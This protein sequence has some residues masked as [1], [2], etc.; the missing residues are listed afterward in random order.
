M[1]EW[2]LRMPWP[3]DKAT[4]AEA[5]LSH[6]WLVTNGLGGYASGTI[7]GVASRRYHSLLVAALPTPL[8]RQVMLNHLSELIRLPDGTTVLFG[9]EERA[10][11]V[12]SLYGADHLTEFRM[13]QGL[14]VWRYEVK[15]YAFEKRVL[16]PHRQN[17]VHVNYRL[18]SGQ[19]AIRLKVRPSVHFRPHEA[20]VSHAHAGPYTFTAIEGRYE[21]KARSDLP[22]LRLFL[23]GERPAF[24]LDGQ[25]IPEVH[26]RV[27]KSRGYEAVGTLWSPGYFRM[28][29]SAEHDATLVAS[30]EPWETLFAL[31]PA[32]ARRAECERRDRL[33]AVA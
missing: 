26:Y 18:V 31:K 6:E 17:T 1:D 5:L 10:G 19:G 4:A 2:N 16:L 8:G 13:E 20:P 28:D 33:L 24:T 27:E 21:L 22:P 32:E 3:R 11:G 9:G 30:T 15:G 29:L 23:Y 25:Y 12:L 7:A 14:P